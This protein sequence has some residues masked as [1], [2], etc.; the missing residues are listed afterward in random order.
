MPPLSRR[1]L[2]LSL[3]TAAM[4][5]CAQSA[6]PLVDATTR[7]QVVESTI[8]EMNALYV[9]PE[10]AKKVE[11]ALRSQQKAGAFE[12]QTTANGFADKMTEALQAVTKDKHIRM[13]Y[14]AEPLDDRQADRAPT[15][16]E[17]ES[18]LR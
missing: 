2:A 8:R 18:Q 13:R 15:A 1:L 14:S 6:G 5:A 3:V 12:Q 7:Q 16:G 17:R 11:A 9:F 4:S 10:M